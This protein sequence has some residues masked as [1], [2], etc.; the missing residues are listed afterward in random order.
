MYPKISWKILPG[1]M[2]DH[3]K[4]KANNYQL[5]MQYLILLCFMFSFSNI[6][7]ISFFQLLPESVDPMELLSYLDPPDLGSSSGA[8]N[9][10]V[11]AVSSTLTTATSSNTT[12]SNNNDDLLALFET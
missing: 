6:A 5:Q 1:Y 7:P 12:S 10:G 2:W 9:C 8:N 4:S 3:R 11:T